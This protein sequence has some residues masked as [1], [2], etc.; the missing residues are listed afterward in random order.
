VRPTDL[1]LEDPQAQRIEATVGLGVVIV[2]QVALRP[3]AQ[4]TPSS[5]FSPVSRSRRI[6][7][8]VTIVARNARRSS[9][10]A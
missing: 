5:K 6:T 3:I 7:S 4:C 8:S 9:W 2:L 1:Q 10:N